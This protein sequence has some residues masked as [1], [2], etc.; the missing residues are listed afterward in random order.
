MYAISTSA[1]LDARVKVELTASESA[2][3]A[4]GILLC[5][6]PLVQPLHSW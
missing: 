6:P 3:A 5:D 2:A 4:P 1:G